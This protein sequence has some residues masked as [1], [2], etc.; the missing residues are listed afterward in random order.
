MVT[1]SNVS[2]IQT[3][4]RDFQTLRGPWYVR[5]SA[6]ESGHLSDDLKTKIQSKGQQGF[7]LFTLTVV[8]SRL[9]RPATVS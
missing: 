6:W 4:D 7:I 9:I 2:V 8:V 5:N 1:H 3:G